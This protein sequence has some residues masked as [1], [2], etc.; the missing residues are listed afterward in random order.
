MLKETIAKNIV[1]L[2]KSA[3]LTQAQ[4]ADSLNYSD[5]AVSKW[6]RGDSLPDVVVLKEIA[7]VFEV[8]VDY[9]LKEDHSE[10]IE[11]NILFEKNK[12]R[13]HLIISML[14]VSVVWFLC[15]FIFVAFSYA[16][17]GVMD[18]PWIVLIYAI[19]LSAIA[20]LVFS[21]LYKQKLGILI[22]VSLIMWG[23]VLA[24]FLTWFTEYPLL[25]LICV[26][27]QLLIY[28][29]SQIKKSEKSDS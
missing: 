27:G 29:G 14:A 13:N 28:L 19:P 5:K 23:L 10:F 18:N 2:R 4:L 6:E 16:E 12:R 25:F 21:I 24:V 8:P 26:P 11:Q 15:T 20:F 22:S 1:N 7:D 3:G 17:L 9:L